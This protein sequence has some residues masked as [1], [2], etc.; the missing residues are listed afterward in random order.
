MNTENPKG[1]TPL[2]MLEGVNNIKRLIDLRSQQVK[3]L[4]DLLKAFQWGVFRPAKFDGNGKWSF[5]MVGG[6]NDFARARIHVTYPDQTDEEILL[7]DLPVELWP[8]SSL[9][10]EYH[11]RLRGDRGGRCWKEGCKSFGTLLNGEDGK[12]YC[13]ACAK[14][15]GHMSVVMFTHTG[16]VF[17]GLDPLAFR[18]A[19]A[20]LGRMSLITLEEYAREHQP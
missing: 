5:N 4:G 2:Q 3:L 9:P 11:P 16:S 18:K 15:T 12:Y 10:P 13:S 8:L 19:Q 14:E 20:I 17:S 1:K 6:I 7:S